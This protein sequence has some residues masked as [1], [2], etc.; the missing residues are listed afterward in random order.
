[1]LAEPGS[2]A[3]L[4]PSGTQQAGSHDPW[5]GGDAYERDPGGPGPPVKFQ[6]E[7]QVGQLGPGIGGDEPV[8][9]LAVEIGEVDPSLARDTAGQGDDPGAG[10]GQQG[11]QQPSGEREVPEVVSA[12]VRLE[13]VGGEAAGTTGDPGIADQDVHPGLALEEAVGEP[14]D[15]GK[16]RE[17][18]DLGPHLASARGGDLLRSPPASILI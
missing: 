14:A 9:A 18:K 2:P 7:H 12:E 17:V 16:V 1:Q 15:R 4:I 8:V 6:R 5:V 13:P 11:G 3:P 10:P